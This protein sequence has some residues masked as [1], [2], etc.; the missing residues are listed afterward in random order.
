MKKSLKDIQNCLVSKKTPDEAARRRCNDPAMDQDLEIIEL[1][2]P[3][4]VDAYTK[5][6]NSKAIRRLYSKTQVISTSANAHIRTRATHTFEV[7]ATNSLIARTL[8]LNEGLCIAM[9]MGHDLGHTPFGHQGEKII[10]KFIGREF[11]HQV[12]SVIICQHIERSGRGLNLTWQTLEGILNHSRSNKT[13]EPGKNVSQESNAVMC[14]DKISYIC[15][16]FNDIFVRTNLLYL[17]DF[18]ELKR[19]INQCGANQRARMLFFVR[20]L[21]YESAEKGSVEFKDSSEAKIFE[22]IKKIMYASVYPVVNYV[23]AE[24]TLIR[25]YEILNEY[26]SLKSSTISPAMILALMTDA[27]IV[28]LI[29]RLDAE[30]TCGFLNARRKTAIVKEILNRSSVSDIL[31]NARIMGKQI[32]FANPD[33]DW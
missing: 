32:D 23:E 10:G 21:C 7:T 18:P 29:N 28:N 14:A 1:G 30:L 6:L 2:S 33:M 27:D 22:E 17:D 9:A 13:L 3:Y 26:E 31:K 20:A 11:K 8:G 12:M 24:Q 16:D 15:S 4:G 5:I 19:L 25:V